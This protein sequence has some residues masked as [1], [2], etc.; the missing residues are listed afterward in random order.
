MT[1]MAAVPMHL[2]AAS[3]SESCVGMA[4]CPAADVTTSSTVLHSPAA[5]TLVQLTKEL[6]AAKARVE[7]E[8]IATVHIATGL[9]A[10]LRQAKQDADSAQQQALQADQRANQ[11]HK[12]TINQINKHSMVVAALLSQWA[13]AHVASL[14]SYCGLPLSLQS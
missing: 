6:E 8:V 7:E 2:R 11:V 1:S 10:R 5:L 9:E 12:C 14:L 3:T 4:L 13:A